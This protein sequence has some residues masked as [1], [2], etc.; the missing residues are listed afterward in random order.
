M[1]KSIVMRIKLSIAKTADDIVLTRDFRRF[2][3]P[4]SVAKSIKTL[5]AE[6]ILYRIGYGVYAKTESSIVDGR[7]IPRLPLEDLSTQFLD[8]MGVPWRLGRAQREYMEGGTQIPVSVAFDIGKRRIARK[9]TV[10]V[11]QLQY[12]RS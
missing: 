2:G 11:R 6:G 9:L 1:K 12:E 10:G 3:S 8:R 5:V 7:P 4:A